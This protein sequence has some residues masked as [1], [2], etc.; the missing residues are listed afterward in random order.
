MF[1][2]IREENMEGKT[3]T[4]IGLSVLLVLSVFSGCVDND[5]FWKNATNDD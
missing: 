2:V 5:F 4:V 1:C 3:L